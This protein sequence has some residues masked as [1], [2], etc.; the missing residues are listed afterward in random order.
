M[1]DNQLEE[2]EISIEQAK[3]TIEMME[4][5]SRLRDNRDFQKVIEE[6]YFKDEASRLV[7]LRA[8]DAARANNGELR[9]SIDEQI[10][11]IGQLRDYF[12]TI[13]GLGR[14][15]KQSLLADEQTREEILAEVV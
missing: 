8:T 5:L 6:G 15:A 1:N 2:V 3:Q 9:T 12:S 10:V 11:G 14:M 4:A 13:Y 7:L